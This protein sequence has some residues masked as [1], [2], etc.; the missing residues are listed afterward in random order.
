M[1]GQ[2]RNMLK[3]LHQRM[4]FPHFL[5]IVMLFYSQQRESDTVKGSPKNSEICSYKLEVWLNVGVHPIDRVFKK[6]DFLKSVL[7]FCKKLV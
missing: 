1:E 4:E 7:F 6:P 2:A 5:F 3:L